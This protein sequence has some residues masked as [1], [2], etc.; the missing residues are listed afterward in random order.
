[1]DIHRPVDRVAQSVI[2]IAVKSDFSL[3]QLASDQHVNRGIFDE[4]FRVLE[5][6][7]RNRMGGTLC[8][9]TSY[10]PDNLFLL[11]RALNIHQL[12]PCQ[13]EEP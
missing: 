6:G 10:D 11:T 8:A 1:M 12:L 2:A 5:C 4:L 9:D 7:H 3:L 13:G